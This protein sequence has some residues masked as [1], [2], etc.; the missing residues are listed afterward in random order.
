MRCFCPK[1]F[2][3]AFLL[4][5]LLASGGGFAVWARGP[6]PEPDT[7]LLH[8]DG[9]VN[10]QDLPRL[11][12]RD[13]V[14]R[15]MPFLVPDLQELRDTKAQHGAARTQPAPTAS[16]TE[17]TA[18]LTSPSPAGLI[19]LRR[20]ESGGWIPPDTQVGVGPNHIVEAV[21]LEMRIWLKETGAVL[22]TSSLNSFF[23][24]SAE[25]SD[26]KIRF[27]AQSGRWFIAV[28]SYNTSFTAGAWR[29][30][31]STT[32]DPTTFVR[33]TAAT[34]KS[35]PDF[36]A[37]GING[38]KVV[39]T[40]NAFRGN[41]FLGTEFL[42]IN[43]AQLVS[44]LSAASS[45]FPP[46]QGLFTIQ[47]AQALLSACTA[48]CPFYMAA[49]AYNSATSIRVWSLQGVPGVG[50][51]VTVA[52]TDR[53]INALTSPP[54]A[55]QLGTS[56]LIQTNDNRLLDAAWAN[57]ALWV[58]A[59][60]ACV[61]SQDTKTR[62]CL[63]FIQVSTTG[64]I[65]KAQDFDFGQSGLYYYYPA[66]QIDGSGNLISVFS[67]SSAG[68]YAGVYAS[69]RRPGDPLNSFQSPVLVKAG[70]H[71]YTPSA[72]R[73]G[74]YSGASLDPSNPGLVW[75]AGEYARLEGGA[76]WGTWITP[77]QMSPPAP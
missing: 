26:P 42:V 21:N 56:T 9:V 58:S 57:G 18:G 64:G 54:D 45:Y 40:A 28:I 63:R 75:V 72:S 48:A 49:V 32:S 13:P 29:L 19:G 66:I 8:P 60:S 77:V 38:D 11:G 27:D 50:V 69:G 65:T 2:A 14:H 51:G 12:P 7:V 74:D 24:T 5:A 6:A 47:P 15:E 31:V 71:S 73:W 67:G 16:A 1:V 23:E 3:V 37:L 52:T 33:Y 36:P 34:S 17:T 70:E 20:S 53:P 46:P 22:S 76:E 41:S 30:A 39:L 4:L 68:L 35:A 62:A 61:P 25:L 43:K 10:V 44:G 55:Q 59:T